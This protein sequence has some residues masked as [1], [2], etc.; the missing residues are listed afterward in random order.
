MRFQEK[1]E[2]SL[3]WLPFIKFLQA[4]LCPVAPY[5]GQGH[6]GLVS[7]TAPVIITEIPHALSKQKKYFKEARTIVLGCS[8]CLSIFQ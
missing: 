3:Q 8:I 2:T 1:I 5:I 6:S 4:T 7:P